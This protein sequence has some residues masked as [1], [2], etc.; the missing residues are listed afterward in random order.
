MFDVRCANGRVF[1]IVIIIAVR[2]T[3][4]TL[5]QVGYIGRYIF[6]VLPYAK[7]K[8]GAN[9][10]LMQARNNSL[11]SVDILDRVNFLEVFL[12]RYQA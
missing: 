6:E 8:E 3:N 9:T 12:N 2:Q 5:T 7:T 11:K 4:A 10:I 1:F